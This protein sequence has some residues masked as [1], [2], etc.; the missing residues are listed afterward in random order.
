MIQLEEE[1]MNVRLEE[2]Q[3]ADGQEHGAEEGD[4]Q[5]HAD[6]QGELRQRP[7][8]PD[9]GQPEHAP[10]QDQGREVSLTHIPPAHIDHAWTI[11]GDWLLN[12]VDR[13]GDESEDDV[14]AQLAE[15]GYQLW[16]VTRGNTP[17]AGLITEVVLRKGRKAL[18]YRYLGGAEF[19]LI[20]G[21]I[22]RHTEAWARGL[23]FGAGD[24][25]EAPCRPGVGRGLERHGWRESCR[26]YQKVLSDV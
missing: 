16:L 21:P 19:D 12:A 14:I 4:Q 25:I 3:Q 22:L 8:D 18:L 1:T 6:Q 7:V 24:V 2:G 10:G 17:L 26:I 23:G 15:G 20:V 11:V 9:P 5:R 13:G